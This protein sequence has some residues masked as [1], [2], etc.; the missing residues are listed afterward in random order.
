MIHKF[1]SLENQETGVEGLTPAAEGWVK[2]REESNIEARRYSNYENRT[3]S[4]FPDRPSPF[5]ES[6]L[7]KILDDYASRIRRINDRE[8][9]HKKESTTKANEALGSNM[10]LTTAKKLENIA[11]QGIRQYGWLGETTSSEEAYE[12]GYV[13][14]EIGLA[15]PDKVDDYMIIDRDNYSYYL[16]YDDVVNRIDSAW[17]INLNN[18]ETIYVGLDFTVNDGR[19]RLSR[20][21]ISDNSAAK[22]ERDR[23]LANKLAVSTHSHMRLPFGC[24]TITFGYTDYGDQVGSRENPMTVRIV[25]RYVISI[26]D[27]DVNTAYNNITNIGKMSSVVSAELQFKVLSQIHEQNKLYRSVISRH[28]ADSKILTPDE[29]RALS[30]IN[31]LDEIVWNKLMENMG[32][33]YNNC[34]RFGGDSK[35]NYHI[36]SLLKRLKDANDSGEKYNCFY[37]WLRDGSFRYLS[38]DDGRTNIGPDSAYTESI[39][40]TR[41][42]DEALAKS[43]NANVLAGNVYGL[44]DRSKMPFEVNEGGNKDLPV[45]E[46]LA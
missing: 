33:L 27:N 44:K 21:E 34:L 2:L 3:F 41:D 5:S 42:L 30:Q 43:E 1:I 12:D 23:Y 8:C 36:Q 20:K 6:I 16:P 4:D 39:D 22:R 10:K 45:I 38:F 7:R 25:P 35:R 11:A 15:M 29:K 14:R 46:L 19:N 18:G 9:S 40:M 31:G 28:G 24:S 13:V 17:E 32:I 37:E 26:G